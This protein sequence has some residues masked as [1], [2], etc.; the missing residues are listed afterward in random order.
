MIGGRLQIDSF[1]AG[2]IR[3][4]MR[5]QSAEMEEGVRI[6]RAEL[7][8]REYKSLRRMCVTVCSKFAKIFNVVMMN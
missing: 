7:K 5:N 6:S 1:V 3:K 4:K 8:R 2:M